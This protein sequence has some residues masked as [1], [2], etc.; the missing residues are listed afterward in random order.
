MKKKTRK[1][2]LEVNVVPDPRLT[3][4]L[5]MNL[6]DANDPGPECAT[7][8]DDEMAEYYPAPRT[9][10]PIPSLLADLDRALDNL[11][12]TAAPFLRDDDPAVPAPMADSPTGKTIRA[13]INRVHNIASRVD[14]V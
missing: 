4:V 10:A 7:G 2:R 6:P 3:E 5:K 9:H 11:E 14:V 12:R 8:R 1:R 13:L